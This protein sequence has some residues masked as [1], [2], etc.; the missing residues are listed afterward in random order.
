[1]KDFD[2]LRYI[3]SYTYGI[4]SHLVHQD[5][6]RVK[7]IHDRLSKS[8]EEAQSDQMAHASRQINDLLMMAFFRTAMTYH[9]YKTGGKP[10][11][12]LFDYHQYFI[13]EMAKIRED[14]WT[15]FSRNHK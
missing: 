13:D 2:A 10:V 1:M 3:L 11:M 12:D 5:A 4:G 8:A 7:L 6:T 9:L 15:N 14:W